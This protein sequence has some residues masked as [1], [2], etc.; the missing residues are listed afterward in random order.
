MFRVYAERETVGLRNDT[1]NNTIRCR[2]AADFDGMSSDLLTVD[3]DYLFS[4]N[5][6]A[7]WI[8]SAFRDIMSTANE[9]F[10][11]AKH[12]KRVSNVKHY[13]RSVRIA[14]TGRTVC[15]GDCKLILI[16][17]QLNCLQIS[18]RQVQRLDSQIYK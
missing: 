4:V 8:W 1:E 15:G 16:V 12:I 5:L 9:Q 3:W 18:S 14:L 2:R 6:S 17:H 10:V 11:R 13:A 7:E